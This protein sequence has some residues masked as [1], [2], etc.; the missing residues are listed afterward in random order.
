MLS[1]PKPK[2]A[3]MPSAVVRYGSLS[4]AAARPTTARPATATI[5]A[6]LNTAPTCAAPWAPAEEPSRPTPATTPMTAAHSR[7][8]RV[9]ADQPR[10]D[11]RGH[12]EVRRDEGLHHEQ[13]KPL[14]GHELGHEAER[15]EA[16]A[17]HEPPL[18][19]HAHHETGIDAAGRGVLEAPMAGRADGNGLHHRSNAVEHRRDDRRDQAD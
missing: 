16:D 6:S 18:V 13:G 14:Q 11:H 12:R 9:I 15:V 10:G 8:D 2:P 5:R 7:Q 19:Q 17:G 3:V 1:T 4:L